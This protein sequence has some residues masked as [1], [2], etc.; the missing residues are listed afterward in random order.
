MFNPY[1]SMALGFTAALITLWI[2]ARSTY[3]P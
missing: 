2:I 3:H 1:F